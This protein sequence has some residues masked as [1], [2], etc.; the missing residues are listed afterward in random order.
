MGNDIVKKSTEP[1][2]H[3]FMYSL[4]TSFQ[5]LSITC[6]A[7]IACYKI[8]INQLFTIYQSGFFPSRLLFQFFLSFCVTRAYLCLAEVLSIYQSVHITYFI[9]TG[10]PC[11]KHQ[12][13]D[14]EFT[15]VQFHSG[16]QH[17]VYL[18]TD[19]DKTFTALPN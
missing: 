17:Y 18:Y 4:I 1:L 2:F 12:S 7:F 14:N 13:Y 5:C 9:I 8:P 19:A 3:S 6:N 10:I 11:R 16:A 15:L